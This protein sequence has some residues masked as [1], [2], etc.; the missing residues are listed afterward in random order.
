MRDLVEPPAGQ[1]V[2]EEEI[3]DDIEVLAQ[4][5]ILED[6]G[7]AELQRLAGT[8]ERDVAAAE[9]DRAR[10]RLMHAGKNLDQGRLAGAV[11][12]DQ[13]HD[14]AGLH[15]EIDVGQRR[16][17]AEIL[18]NIAQPEDRLVPSPAYR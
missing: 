17:R 7:N 13:R 5:Q 2:S 1:L 12:A 15:F 18:G 6:G 3:G 9:F 16:N 14:L 10:G 11:V 4:R 8:I